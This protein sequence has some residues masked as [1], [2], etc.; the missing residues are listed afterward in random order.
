MSRKPEVRHYARGCELGECRFAVVV[1]GLKGY[2]MSMNLQE[3][4]DR[5]EINNLLIDYCTALDQRDFD[6]FDSLFT[7]DAQIDYSAM[8]GAKGDLVTIKAW[9]QKTMQQFPMSQHLIA[10]SRVWIEGDTARARTMCHNPMQMPNG[11]GS[12]QVAFLGLWYV[13]RLLRTADGWRIAERK[14]EFGYVFN[15]PGR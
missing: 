4:S 1:T 9:L 15:M 10:N 11:E 3:I 2:L 12:H 13:D 6:A 8:G 5:L 7:P 14:E